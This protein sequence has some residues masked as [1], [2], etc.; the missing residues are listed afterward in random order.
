M[1]CQARRLSAQLLEDSG[2]SRNAGNWVD[3]QGD[4]RG[5]ARLV[6]GPLGGPHSRV[7]RRGDSLG[8]SRDWA[9]TCGRA[10]AVFR[11]LDG[12]CPGNESHSASVACAGRGRGSCSRRLCDD[13]SDASTFPDFSTDHLG[14]LT[15]GTMARSAKVY[16]QTVD[17]DAQ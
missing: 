17:P 12:I 2:D 5:A 3:A 16:D 7:C 4:E 6:P 14:P 1:P 8:G 11:P 15:E 9:T 13:S 10:R